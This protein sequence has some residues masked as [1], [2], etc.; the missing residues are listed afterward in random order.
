MQAPRQNWQEAPCC[1]HTQPMWCRV[2]AGQR[3]SMSCCQHMQ[4][5][6]AQVA[7]CMLACLKPGDVLGLAQQLRHDAACTC[8]GDTLHWRS[9]GLCGRKQL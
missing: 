7:C 8:S 5:S 4:K 6:L 3:A 2:I 9:C 1:Q